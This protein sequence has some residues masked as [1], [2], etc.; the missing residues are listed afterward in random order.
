MVAV[1]LT[2]ERRMDHP[3]SAQLRGKDRRQILHRLGF[4]V[5][6]TVT[7]LEAIQVSALREY[8]A[9]R[10]PIGQIW[11]LGAEQ[12]GMTALYAAAAD[13][14][15]SGALVVDYFQK[16]EN[17]WKEPVDRMLYGQLI[18][19]GDAEVA[20]LVAPRPLVLA[21]TPD[22]P[23]PVATRA[24]AG[25]GGLWAIRRLIWSMISATSTLS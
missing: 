17:A 6:R 14:R 1:P 9:Q 15:I 5:G 16:R 20:A 2:V 13:E 19:F 11:V 21:T 12:G 18:E 7:G 4:I 25:A 22:G 24:P 8:L 10:F 23:A 3:L